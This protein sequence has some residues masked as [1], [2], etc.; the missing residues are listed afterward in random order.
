M[1][2]VVTIYLVLKFSTTHLLLCISYS[3]IKMTHIVAVSIIYHSSIVAVFWL[4]I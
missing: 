4:L 1:E 3:F 2:D